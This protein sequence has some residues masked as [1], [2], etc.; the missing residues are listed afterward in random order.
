M[1]LVFAAISTT[2]P[3]SHYHEIAEV[4]A[5]REP[6]SAAAGRSR[7]LHVHR[8]AWF[9]RDRADQRYLDA[10]GYDPSWDGEAIPV[11]WAL[12]KLEE[13]C[14]EGDTLVMCAP[15]DALPFLEAAGCRLRPRVRVLDLLS[16]AWPLAPVARMP[17]AALSALCGA[18][19][20]TA[21]HQPGAVGQ[22]DLM[23]RVYE[24][25]MSRRR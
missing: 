1:H 8:R 22:V 12:G 18:L 13:V 14:F 21:P 25:L 2:G 10:A 7:A 9:C 24:A 6:A 11:A 23:V 17:G 15:H 20:I 4:A 3:H 16:M 19:G 5:R